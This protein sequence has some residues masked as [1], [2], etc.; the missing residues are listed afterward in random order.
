MNHRQIHRW[1]FAPVCTWSILLTAGTCDW[2]PAA[3]SPSTAY[4]DDPT[5]TLKAQARL[6]FEDAMDLAK[7]N[8]HADA[9]PKF[10]ESQRL[11]P[12]VGTK[13]YL[14]DCYEHIG[15]YASAWGLYMEVSDEAG[16]AKREEYSRKRADALKPKLTR[17]VIVLADDVKTITGIEVR[18]DGVVVPPG[19]WGMPL[20]VD[21]GKHTIGV[22][23]PSKRSWETTV[24]ASGE[25]AVV[26]VTIPELRDDTV[27]PPPTALPTVQPTVT[28][29]VAPTTSA[30]PTVAPDAPWPIQKKLALA[31]G[32]VGLVGVA[33][34]GVMGGLAAGKK[35]DMDA[36]CSQSDPL[37]CNAA[38]VALASDV[39]TF[40][41]VSTIGLIAGGALAVGGVVLWL[42]APSSEPE[43]AKTTGHLRTSVGVTPGGLVVKGSW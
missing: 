7:K 32:A 22:G 1:L 41:T 34:G 20:P 43:K 27:I 31:A 16:D 11:D 4:A 37:K 40:G 19:Q 8:R 9:C 42:T 6:L 15:R 38:G 17:M 5:A 26:T 28:A 14:A 24:E 18:R 3:L 36:Q 33:V 23:A 2:A 35:G 39:K 25:G 21:A 30:A 29:T 13:F 12:G 10:E